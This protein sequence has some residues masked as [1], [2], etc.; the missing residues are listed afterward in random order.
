MIVSPILDITLNNC[1]S[2]HARHF[3]KHCTYMIS[4]NPSNT[5]F[6][7]RVLGSSGNRGESKAQS[8]SGCDSRYP[9][10]QGTKPLCE[11]LSTQDLSFSTCEM[12]ALDAMALRSTCEA[13]KGIS[14]R[15]WLFASCPYQ[16]ENFSVFPVLLQ[17]SS[18]PG[19]H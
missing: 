13:L 12:E 3:V 18:P 9:P 10:G 6:R 15:G 2:F 5:T 11:M 17:N 8:S 1:M 14:R 7:V 19:L 16:W 4:L